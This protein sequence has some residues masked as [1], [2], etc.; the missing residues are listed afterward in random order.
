MAKIKFELSTKKTDRPEFLIKYLE[1][2][3]RRKF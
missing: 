3:G 2:K 1:K